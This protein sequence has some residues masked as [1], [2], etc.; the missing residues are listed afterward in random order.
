MLQALRGASKRGA[1]GGSAEKNKPPGS[2][3]RIKKPERKQEEPGDAGA[4][5]ARTATIWLILIIASAQYFCYMAQNVGLSWAFGHRGMETPDMLIAFTKA[6]CY[7]YSFPD[8]MLTLHAMP[9]HPIWA[10]VVAGC[11]KAALV[12]LIVY[13]VALS[14]SDEDIREYQLEKEHEAKYQKYLQSKAG[15]RERAREKA[16]E[17]KRAAKKAD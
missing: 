12:W 16:R 5:M 6:Q 7:V 13:A 17:A 15:E 8:R 10:R 11:A 3:I 9:N 1:Q 2:D 4:R 14:I